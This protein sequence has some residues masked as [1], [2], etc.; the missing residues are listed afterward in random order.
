MARKRKDFY[1]PRCILRIR[2]LR[3]FRIL[4]IL[5]RNKQKRYICEE[6]SRRAI[7]KRAEREL[8]KELSFLDS[9]LTIDSLARAVGTNRTY[10]SQSVR[11]EKGLAFCEYINRFRIDYAKSY[12]QSE[13][14]KFSTEEVAIISGFGSKRNFVRQFRHM[15]GMT[16]VQ[17]YKRLKIGVT[18]PKIANLNSR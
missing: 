4:N 9:S 2:V 15:E 1:A 10:L 17:Y 14:A 7:M 12:M 8:T 6:S 5:R 3:L 13:Q 11:L 18:K 16:P